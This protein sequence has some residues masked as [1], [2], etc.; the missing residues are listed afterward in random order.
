MIQQRNFQKQPIPQIVWLLF[1]F[2][3]AFLVFCC[4]KPTHSE[5]DIGEVTDTLSESTPAPAQTL[6]KGLQAETG[7]IIFDGT[8]GNDYDL[9][10]IFLLLRPNSVNEYEGKYLYKNQQQ[11][12]SIKGNIENGA[13]HL[14]E[15]NAKGEVT[16]L[17]TGDLSSYPAITG[18]WSKPDGSGVLNFSLKKILPLG[19]TENV[20]GTFDFVRLRKI[21]DGDNRTLQIIKLTPDSIQSKL[22]ALLALE[23]GH[24]D[25]L[26]RING[27]TLYNLNGILTIAIDQESNGG[28]QSSEYKCLNVRTGRS[29]KFEDI[30]KP[31]S[32]KEIAKLIV[33]KARENCPQMLDTDYSEDK[34]NLDETPPIVTRGGIWFLS[35]CERSAGYFLGAYTLS[36]SF[37][38]MRPYLMID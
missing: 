9:Y 26:K 11:F 20:R 28:W 12:I 16:G 13:L 10:E 23:G 18:T 27:Y 8:I 32:K 5:N 21:K 15:T 30:F 14:T 3:L 34:I 4:G 24:I 1:N 37:E 35:P 29:L 22:N 31:E 38:E 36:F 25:D 2:L 19:T 6:L 17:F 33:S 7:E